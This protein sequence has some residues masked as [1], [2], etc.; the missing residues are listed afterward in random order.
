[1]AAS[2]T[3]RAA[4]RATGRRARQ[5]PAL[6]IGGDAAVRPRKGRS[7]P[8]LPR[9]ARRESHKR[10]GASLFK[11]NAKGLARGERRDLQGVGEGGVTGDWKSWTLP[12]V[13]IQSA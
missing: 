3:T 9:Y 8:R 12:Q 10:G 5:F 1:M 7:V 11:L 6:Y 2:P 4:P 13:D